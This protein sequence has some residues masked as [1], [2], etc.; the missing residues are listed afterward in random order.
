MLT[1]TQGPEGIISKAVWD[2]GTTGS[3]GNLENHEAT[4]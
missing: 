1:K 2:E 4:R 3:N